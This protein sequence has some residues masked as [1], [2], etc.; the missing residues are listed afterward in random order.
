M[1]GTD[2]HTWEL[3]DWKGLN[4]D[5][6]IMDKDPHCA[7]DCQNVDFDESGMITKRRGTE[8]M[9]TAFSKRIN[10]IYDF[11]SQQG[12]KAVDDRHRIIVISG[13]MLYVLNED[14]TVDASFL[15]DDIIHYAIT[16]DIGICFISNE[17]EGEVPK[18]LCYV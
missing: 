9:N 10:M 2:F 4:T 7:E 17:N 15:V 1:A 11:Q 13:D 18:M 3:K 5:P 6:N 12:F 16:N 14:H 8:R